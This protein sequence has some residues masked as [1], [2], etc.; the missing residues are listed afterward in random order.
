MCYSMQKRHTMSIRYD[1]YSKLCNVGKFGES[2]SDVLDRVLNSMPKT[3]MGE[4]SDSDDHIVTHFLYGNIESNEHSLCEV[5]GKVST[6]CFIVIVNS[7]KK[8]KTNFDK[9]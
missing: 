8:T 3:K 1:V 2:L 4:I 9:P 6:Y 7:T 5:H